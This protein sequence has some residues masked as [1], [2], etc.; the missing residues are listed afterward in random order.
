MLTQDILQ[1]DGQS[2]L[3]KYA[4][5][6]L[7]ELTSSMELQKAQLLK[8]GLDFDKMKA[9]AKDYKANQQTISKESDTVSRNSRN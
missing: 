8:R 5:K 3:F 1:S 4:Q 7:K 9:N 6:L 2:G